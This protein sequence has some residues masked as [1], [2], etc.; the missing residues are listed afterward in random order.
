MR[1]SADQ[2]SSQTSTASAS[3]SFTES[4][5]TALHLHPPIAMAPTV[6]NKDNKA[7]L[8]NEIPSRVFAVVKEHHHIDPAMPNEELPID[9][10]LQAVFL[11]GSVLEDEIEARKASMKRHIELQQREMELKDKEIALLKRE[12]ELKDR[13]M[14]L[15]RPQAQDSQQGLHGQQDVEEGREE[16]ST[17][18]P[19]PGNTGMGQTWLSFK[20]PYR[21][22]RND[23]GSP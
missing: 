15:L 14:A 22:R 5:I 1:R 12:I 20:V 2:A 19:T 17:A 11:Y 8:I 10:L 4:H 6:T 18:C 7:A 3:N 23:V 13:E 16:Q 21:S 9:L